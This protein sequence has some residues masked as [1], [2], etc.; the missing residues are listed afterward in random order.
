MRVLAALQSVDWVVSFSEDT[1]QRLICR[2]LP[3]ILVKGGDYQPQD[4]AGHDCVKRNHGDVIVLGYEE[5]CSTTDIID[6]IFRQSQKQ[7]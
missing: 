1:P 5:G 7:D 4:V 2:I 3:D 6:T